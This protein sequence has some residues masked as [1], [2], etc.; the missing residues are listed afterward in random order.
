MSFFASGI[1]WEAAN[2]RGMNVEDFYNNESTRLPKQIK[3]KINNDI[4]PVCMSCTLWEQCLRWGFAN[5]N[6]GIWGGLSEYERESF[7]VSSMP[8]ARKEVLEVME[9][10]GI[11]E[12]K[13]RSL[14]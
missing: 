3:V 13:I 5:E 11:D 1:D 14:M 12:E 4:R 2:C 6:Y 8:D 10:Y 9:G 7:R